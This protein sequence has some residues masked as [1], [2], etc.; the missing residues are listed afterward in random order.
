VPTRFNFPSSGSAPVTPAFSAG[1]VSTGA[2]RLPLTRGAGATGA[3]TLSN[4]TT[5]GVGVD[6]NHLVAQYV[7]ETV[8]AQTIAAQALDAQFRCQEANTASNQF[9]TIRI[10]VVSNDGSTVRGVILD[11]TRDDLEMSAAAQQNR[12]FTATTTQVV[13][14][15][16]DRIVV[17]VGTGGNPA[18]TGTHDVSFSVRDNSTDLPEDDTQTTTGNPWLEFTNEI[19]GFGT[20]ADPPP[21]VTSIDP[22]E[23]DVAGG[24]AVTITGTDFVDGATVT[25]GGDAAASVIFVGSTSITC[26]TPAHA[27]GA[28]DVV[29]TNPDLQTDT[30][31][32]GFTYT[33]AAAGAG[34]PVAFF[35]K[36]RRR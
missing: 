29:V 19:T 13:T 14:L 11:T 20:A 4:D 24:T 26:D 3:V 31:A 1:W 7:G 8:A 15:N 23:G 17:E 6:A 12:R 36:R 9:L 22:A 33:E 25:L 16:G 5:S 30:L 34:A 28:V 10:L 21:T 27:A 32:G 35:L 2:V 18:A